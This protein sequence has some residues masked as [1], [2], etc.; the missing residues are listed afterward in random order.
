MSIQ[1]DNTKHTVSR[2]ILDTAVIKVRALCYSSSELIYV[3]KFYQFIKHHLKRHYVY[4]CLP[5]VVTS[6]SVYFAVYLDDNVR[7]RERESL[8][9]IF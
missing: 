5:L 8:W 9:I 6:V 3:Y 7:E 1:R 4:I 2:M